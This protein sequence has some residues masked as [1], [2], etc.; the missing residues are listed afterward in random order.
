[1]RLREKMVKHKDRMNTID[2]LAVNT[3]ECV[4]SAM[5]WG[6]AD[7][8]DDDNEPTSITTKVMVM[9]MKRCYYYQII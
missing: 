3:N 4:P 1:M 8:D 6:D 5:Q 9:A 7:D 2:I